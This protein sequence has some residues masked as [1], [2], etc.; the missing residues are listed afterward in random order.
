MKVV[1]LI[2]LDL[3]AVVDGLADGPRQAALIFLDLRGQAWL[4]GRGRPVVGTYGLNRLTAKNAA[5]AVAGAAEAQDRV[6]EVV[7]EPDRI[8]DLV[9]FVLD[10]VEG[11][12]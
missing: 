11:F 5:V 3:G 12:G 8:Q 4:G 6:L 10:H 7:A 9:K 1:D 2:E